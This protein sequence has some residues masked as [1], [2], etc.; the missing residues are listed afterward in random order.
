MPHFPF[1]QVFFAPF[2]FPLNLKFSHFHYSLSFANFLSSYFSF[3]LAEREE[4]AR[5]MVR[6]RQ[7]TN[8]DRI[9]KSRQR[10]RNENG[11]RQG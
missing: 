10:D 7:E 5:E 11:V 9:E 1:S 2:L 8:R 3:C 6:E 4:K